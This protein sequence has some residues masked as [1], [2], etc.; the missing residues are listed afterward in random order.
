MLYCNIFR[1][2][3]ISKAC[4]CDIL[5]ANIKNLSKPTYSKDDIRKNIKI[6]SEAL[7]QKENLSKFV[8]KKSHKM[9]NELAN[10]L[11]GNSV[12]S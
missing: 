3:Q 11:T 9:L 6:L 2:S 1:A 10:I 8:L 7:N 4:Q 5:Q 12:V